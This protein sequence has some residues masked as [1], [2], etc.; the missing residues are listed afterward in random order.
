MAK[1][2]RV[3]PA[4]MGGPCAVYVPELG[5]HEVPNP[6]Q[7]YDEDDPIVRAA[8]WM[9]VTDD[10]PRRCGA[11][12]PGDRGHAIETA[13]RAPGRAAQHPS[14]V[15]MARAPY[16]LAPLSR[17]AN[18][19][20]IRRPGSTSGPAWRWCPGSAVVG[21]LDGGGWSACF[22]LSYRDLCIHDAFH[23]SGWP[24]RARRAAGAD[25]L[26][27]HPREPQQGGP[28][29]LDNTRGEWLLFIDTDMGFTPTPSTG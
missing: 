26:G 29:F 17:A 18:A 24:A 12:R 28:G 19:Q 7:P 20:G 9:F 25:R 6:A 21:F 14:A 23:G 5:A 2:L 10:E 13:T 3:R 1:I 15:T 11:T 22:G 8:R 16:L 4:H 27:W